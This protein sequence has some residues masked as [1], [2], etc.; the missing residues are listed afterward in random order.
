MLH[1]SG[2]TAAS[3]DVITDFISGT[4]RINLSGI[5]ANTTAI[6]NDAFTFIGTGT[7]SGGGALTAG[8]L[9]YGSVVGGN[10]LIEGDVDGDGLADFQIQLTGNHT[11]TTADLV[12]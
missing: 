2:I 8:Q 4:D 1:Q 3:R 10:T 12:V 5:D 7:F 6:G 9:R 11:V